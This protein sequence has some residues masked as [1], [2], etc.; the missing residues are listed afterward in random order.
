MTPQRVLLGHISQANGLRGDVLIKSH[1]AVPEDIAA[2]GPLTNKDGSRAFDIRVV[3]VTAKGVV[4]K[5]TGVSNRDASEALRGTELYIDREKLPAPDEDDFYYADLIGVDA[6]G[7]DGRKVG[8]VVAVQNFGAG[9][10]LEIRLTKAKGTELLPFTKAFVPHVD[11]D[12]GHVTIVWPEDSPDEDGE[13]IED[14]K[15]ET[16]ADE[17]TA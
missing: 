10:L 15:V 8:T 16:D 13:T 3:R 14:D 4:A 7:E 1:T 9:D 12:A 6:I 5:I 11:L 2:Y 17:G